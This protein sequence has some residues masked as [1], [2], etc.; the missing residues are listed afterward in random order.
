MSLFKKIALS[1]ITSAAMLTTTNAT[2]QTTL[3]DTPFDATYNNTTL[4]MPY[5]IPALVETE[6]ATTGN[7]ELIFFGDKRYCGMDIGYGSSASAFGSTNNDYYRIDIVSKRSTD[8]G[9]TWGE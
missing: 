4:K 7:K 1:V 8:G 6:N 9:K 5:R 2:A 3:F